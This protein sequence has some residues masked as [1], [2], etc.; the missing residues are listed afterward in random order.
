MQ[1]FHF[2]LGTDLFTF[3]LLLQM[4]WL[5]SLQISA[6]VNFQILKHG[7]DLN[8]FSV[9]FELWNFSRV[10]WSSNKAFLVWGGKNLFSILLFFWFNL[11]CPD[12]FHYNEN[13]L[14]KSSLSW[15]STVLGYVNVNGC[16]FNLTQISFFFW[17]LCWFLP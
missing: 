4:L 15:E 9:A 1:R 14:Y 13:P 16:W 12:I 2:Q 10:C 17:L 8:T 7:R 3:A 6:V 5:R 11:S